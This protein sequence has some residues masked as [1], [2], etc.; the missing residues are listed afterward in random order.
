[1]PEITPP[2]ES[3]TSTP[4]AA[5]PSPTETED[6]LP[7]WYPGAKAST[8]HRPAATSSSTKEPS[9][10]WNGCFVYGPRP[11]PGPMRITKRMPPCASGW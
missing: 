4:S 1:M 6:A 3:R 5:S 10:A 11:R 2:F 9:S 8:V 7:D